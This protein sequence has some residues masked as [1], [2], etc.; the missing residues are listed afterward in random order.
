L[1]QSILVALKNSASSKKVVDFMAGMPFKAD[2]FEITLLN[3]FRKP[4]QSEEIIG[5][6]FFREEPER[7]KAFMENAREKL[8]KSGYRKE[9]VQIRLVIEPYP[10]IA[11][12]IIDQFNQKDYLLVVIGRRKKSK[13]EEFVMGDVSVKLIR[14][15]DEKAVLVVKSK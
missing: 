7:L 2:N 13:S 15:P 14:A 5:E 1:K 4:S 10:T 8:V 12:G 9:N 6:E 3:V 11:E